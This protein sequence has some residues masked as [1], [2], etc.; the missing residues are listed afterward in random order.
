MFPSMAGTAR[1]LTLLYGAGGSQSDSIV[2]E[3]CVHSTLDCVNIVSSLSQSTATT[4]HVHW[5]TQLGDA[6]IDLEEQNRELKR[7]GDAIAYNR[8][9]RT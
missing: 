9:S 1:Q 8:V 7:I 5:F 3:A 4:R 2:A 6:L